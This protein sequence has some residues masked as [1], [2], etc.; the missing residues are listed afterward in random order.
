MWLFLA[1]QGCVLARKWPHAAKV[2]LHATSYGQ[3]AILYG[4]VQPFSA[5]IFLLL[6]QG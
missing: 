4:Y 5:T 2:R 6:P 1:V 3:A